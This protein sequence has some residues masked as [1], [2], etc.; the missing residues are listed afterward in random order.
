M[1][2]MRVSATG[3]GSL[4]AGLESLRDRY[5]A[6]YLYSDP[7]HFVH[8]YRR[9]GDQEIVGL[10]ASSLAFGNVTL[11]C[12][13]IERVLSV[14]GESPSRYVTRLE[15]RE[16][17][18]SLT[19][20]RHRWTSG[21]DVACLL[22][23]AQQMIERTGSIGAFFHRSFDVDRNMKNALARFSSSVLSLD[24]GGLYRG[25]HLPRSAGVRY[26]FPAP[27]TGGA[28]KR[29]NLYLRWMARPNDNG[30]DLGLWDFV[31]PSHLV[32]PLDVHMSRIGRHL[33][34]TLR[35][36][37]GWNMA[38]DITRA[39][40]RIEPTDP[41][42]YDFALS[43]MGILERCPRHP[44]KRPCDLCDLKRWTRR[45]PA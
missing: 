28:C 25:K 21:R 20:F 42:K 16:A 45:R 18:S 12:R 44:R 8:G 10:I 14:M 27:T 43:R 31:P 33:G 41:T 13:S 29:L 23:Y 37:P 11:I 4:R 39:L 36:T 7:L 15:P 34:W 6:G 38:M 26:F 40:A 2:P 9:P 5:D 3:L 35:K 24:H 1:Q 22:F 19:S 30:L 32:I 17:L